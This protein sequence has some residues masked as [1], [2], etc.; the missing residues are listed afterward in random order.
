MRANS[1]KFIETTH[2]KVA[3]T[4]KWREV[5][6]TLQSTRQREMEE[7]APAA[8]CCMQRYPN[9]SGGPLLIHAGGDRDCSLLRR[10]ALRAFH[11]VWSQGGQDL[12]LQIRRQ[13]AA[14][15]TYGTQASSVGSTE[16]V[17][18]CRGRPSTWRR[19]L[20]S[21][22]SELLTRALREV[23]GGAAFLIGLCSASA[24]MAIIAQ[25]LQPC[26]CGW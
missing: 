25:A 22:K 17:R 24:I 10:C 6:Q 4:R 11:P 21:R 18:E 19:L 1:R 20:P 5:F 2:S 16:A 12:G 3:V 13:T 7:K 26:V 14:N 9:V 8:A 15:V 23:R